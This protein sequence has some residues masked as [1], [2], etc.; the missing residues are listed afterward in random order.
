M[1]DET[2]DDAPCTDCGDTGI[3]Y[4]TERRCACQAPPTPATE[5]R[6]AVALEDCPIGLFISR[7]GSLCLKTEYGDNNGRIDAYIVSS[8]E[9]FWGD[10]PQTVASQRASMVT[11]V[12]YA[13][14]ILAA[15]ANE[16]AR[17]V[18]WLRSSAGPTVEADCY[19]VADMLER[20]ALTANH[21]APQEQQ[22]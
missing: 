14:E 16:R 21:S 4:Q 7:Y 15:E 9:M 13:A 5:E 6:E 11:P 2:W 1:S 17:I 3:T 18:A 10:P 19:T 22:T 12:D 8:G 20:A